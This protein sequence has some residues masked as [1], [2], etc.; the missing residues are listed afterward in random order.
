MIKVTELSLREEY[1]LLQ[2]LET[3]FYDNHN[4]E[5]PTQEKGYVVVDSANICMCEA[6]SNDAQ[7]ILLRFLDKESSKTLNNLEFIPL[8][9]SPQKVKVSM[10]YT[11]NI[12]K[13][14]EM[15]DDNIIITMKS[16]YPICYEN[17]DFKFILAP[18]VESD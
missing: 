10:E 1:K 7:R 12:M 13:V 11:L 14:L 3:I 4:K 5:L 8:E 2:A 9:L 15:T 16:D 17:K 18:R 6:K